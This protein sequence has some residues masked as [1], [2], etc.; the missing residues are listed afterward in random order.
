[1]DTL[2]IRCIVMDN[3]LNETSEVSIAFSEGACTLTDE[4]P[5]VTVTMDI[6]EYSSL[7]FGSVSF[8]TLYRYG[9]VSLSDDTYAQRLIDL[10]GDTKP[11][12]CTVL[13]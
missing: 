9:L 3:F 6:A 7:L 8:E 12:M 2:V 13:F 10:F 11:P 1:M 5:K 4:Q